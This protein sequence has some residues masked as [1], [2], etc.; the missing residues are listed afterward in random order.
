[1][2]DSNADAG[3]ERRPATS[4][5]REL[6]TTLNGRVIPT[7]IGTTVSSLLAQHRHP[8]RFQP[9]GAV[10]NGRLRSL[11]HALVSDCRIDTVDYGSKDGASIYRRTA[12]LILCEAAATIDP[13]FNPTVGQALA[14]GY[15]FTLRRNGE[16]LAEIGAPLVERL[17][18]EMQKIVR[19]GRPVLV[20]KIAVEEAV[21]PKEAGV[22]A[23][24]IVIPRSCS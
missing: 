12:T 13:A 23:E 7:T 6:Q 10:V 5:S 9:L 2:T 22:A 20:R 8:G 4:H 3:P 19:D 14:G 18:Q 17:K 24:V 1:M 21:R 16:S 11:D 15:F